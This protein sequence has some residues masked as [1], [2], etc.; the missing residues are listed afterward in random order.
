[1]ATQEYRDAIRWYSGQ[2]RSA[3][4]GFV[5]DVQQAITNIEA[6]AESYPIDVL[7][8]RWQ[9]LRRYP[10]VLYYFIVDD[11]RCRIV[12]VAHG[13]RRPY[14]WLRRRWRP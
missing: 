7:D 1:L 14:Y 4:T 5:D 2:S 6:S 12:A 8:V 13:G 3:A 9:R 11:S 10:Y